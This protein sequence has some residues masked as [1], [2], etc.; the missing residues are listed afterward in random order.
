[1]QATHNPDTSNFPLW[2]L[3][4]AAI[5][6]VGIGLAQAPYQNGVV[7]QTAQYPDSVDV[8]QLQSLPAPQK[9]VREYHGATNSSQCDK[10]ADRFARQGRRVKLVKKIKLTGSS[11]FQYT[12]AFEGEDSDPGFYLD[13]R[14]N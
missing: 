8:G 7:T 1:M 3:A 2:P 5:A 10:M 9:G 11:F 12:C 13:H 6:V 14:S 4:L